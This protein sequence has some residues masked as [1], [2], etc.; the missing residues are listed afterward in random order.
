MAG[1]KFW[2]KVTENVHRFLSTGHSVRCGI[3]QHT[4]TNI[5][6]KIEWENRTLIMC[7]MYSVS[8]VSSIYFC[9]NIRIRN[10]QNIT[11]ANDVFMCRCGQSWPVQIS[12]NIW[13]DEYLHLCVHI[14]CQSGQSCSNSVAVNTQREQ[15]MD[16]MVHLFFCGSIRF[17]YVLYLYNICNIMWRICGYENNVWSLLTGTVLMIK[18]NGQSSY[19]YIFRIVISI[20][21]RL[22]WT[23]YT[24]MVEVTTVSF[25]VSYVCYI[26]LFIFFL[27]FLLDI[28]Y[29][30]SASKVLFLFFLF[31]SFLPV[32]SVWFYFMEYEGVARIPINEKNWVRVEREKN[33]HQNRATT[34]KMYG[35]S[36]GWVTLNIYYKK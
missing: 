29:E 15:S 35:L 23:R 4:T 13:W 22:F 11:F 6:T 5:E 19:I 20:L 21:L 16:G 1:N 33:N 3:A 31:F 7:I 24:T 32:Y 18:L 27:L 2:H 10:I 28:S 36:L 12:N 30:C 25:C 26:Y 9:W 34:I 8:L 14:F 17:G